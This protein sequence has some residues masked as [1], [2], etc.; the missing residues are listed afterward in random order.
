MCFQTESLLNIKLKDYNKTC[1][2]ICNNVNLYYSSIKYKDIISKD[3]KTNLPSWDDDP[4]I[5]NE[6]VQDI[7]LLEL[8]ISSPPV[9][10]SDGLQHA[11]LAIY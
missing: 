3:L 9:D 6:G 1:Q 4:H 7:L 8:Q 11:Q 2:R 5:D 10:N